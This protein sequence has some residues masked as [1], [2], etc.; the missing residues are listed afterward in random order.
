MDTLPDELI[1]DILSYAT[2]YEKHHEKDAIV[3]HYER[4]SNL[5]ILLQIPCERQK[6]VRVCKRWRTIALESLYSFI[7]VRNPIGLLSL[8]YS[9]VRS[10]PHLAGFVQ[11]FS[12]LSD[13]K[14]LYSDPDLRTVLDACPNL[15]VFCATRAAVLP[16]S[17][18]KSLL[19][20]NI[21]DTF[22][23][24]VRVADATS[25]LQL[26]LF[27]HLQTLR[28]IRESPPYSFRWRRHWRDNISLP[29]LESLI[30]EF[31]DP[32]DQVYE[33]I[34]KWNLPSLSVLRIRNITSYSLCAML[35]NFQ[36]TLIIVDA[37]V[38]ADGFV[39]TWITRRFPMPRLKHFSI[40]GG[41]LDFDSCL[42][43]ATAL[44]T[45]E[46]GLDWVREP[47]LPY[48]SEGWAVIRTDWRSF[49]LDWVTNVRGEGGLSAL[50]EVK[51]RIECPDE[52]DTRLLTEIGGVFRRCL[53]DTGIKILDGI[54]R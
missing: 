7:I 44:E 43:S 49:V 48:D 25:H 5:S 11:A 37:T 26:N 18:Q 9:L 13:N 41:L 32:H 12:I 21:R 22:N 51:F 1:Y 42:E 16:I 30:L 19:Y 50:K 17:Q 20:M 3:A 15:L 4:R 31:G 23:E 24:S 53:P 33:H 34:R 40:T 47:R 38:S 14:W 8:K 54:E 35:N 2:G 45:L 39:Y 6:I 27:T 28:L 52:S 36:S 29:H 46:F 10:S